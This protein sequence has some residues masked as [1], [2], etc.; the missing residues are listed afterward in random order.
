M[1]CVRHDLPASRRTFPAA[2]MAKRHTGTG[3][4][5]PPL[6]CGN[7]SSR[8]HWTCDLRPSL[9]AYMRLQ[10]EHNSLDCKAVKAYLFHIAATLHSPTSCHEAW[11]AVCKMGCPSCRSKARA[12]ELFGERRLKSRHPACCFTR[13]LADT[14]TVASALAG[15]LHLIFEHLRQIFKNI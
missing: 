6:S 10:V 9:T 7:A 2:S 4:G 15:N 14:L 1:D 3:I 12:H 5:L 11:T 8:P 13:K